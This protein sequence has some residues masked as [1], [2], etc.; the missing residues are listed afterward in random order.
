M[1]ALISA[2]GIGFGSTAAVIGFNTSCFRAF[3][4]YSNGIDCLTVSC[5][6]YLSEVKNYFSSSFA[7][8]CSTFAF[9]FVG[10]FGRAAGFPPLL[11]GGGVLTPTILT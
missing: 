10:G 8:V 2:F 3:T 7:S 6:T 4:S 1:E 11:G 9:K 5:S